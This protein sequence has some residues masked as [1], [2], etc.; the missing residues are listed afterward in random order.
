M[1]NP[2]PQELNWVGKRAA[3]TVAQTFKEV[4]IGINNDVEAI[5]AA[6]NIPVE[7]RFSADLTTKGTTVGVGQHGPFRAGRV[8]IGIVGETIEV[9]DGV[10]QPW[11][12]TVSLNNEGRCTL[13]LE[14]GTELEQ[15]QF[16]K[17][18]L[19]SLFFGGL[20]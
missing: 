8:M 17:K 20:A 2:I 14:D 10:T 1:A 6:R 7:S 5:N 15:W 4:L 19:E 9:R 3:C 12:V 13:K 11:T 16:R 18:A